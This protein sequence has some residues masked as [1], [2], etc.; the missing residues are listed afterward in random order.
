MNHYLL[1]YQ[2][3]IV[4][5]GIVTTV[6]FFVCRKKKP[7]LIPFALF[8]LCFTTV[9]LSSFLVSYA[10]FNV[11]EGSTIF[12]FLTAGLSAIIENAML[13][14][15]VRTYHVLFNFNRQKIE[16]LIGISMA[17]ASFMLVTPV[18]IEFIPKISAYKL[19][20]GYY[21]FAFI[22]FVVFTYIISISILRVWKIVDKADRHF[23]ILLFIFT[24]IGYIQSNLSTY[25]EL[26]ETVRVLTAE[27]QGFNPSTV[28]YLLFSLF[29]INLL[30][31]T[32][33][34][35]AKADTVPTA[36][37]LLSYGFSE[38]EK[39]LV[40]LILSGIS[41]QQIA[42]EL[43]ISLATVKTHLNKIFKKSDVKSRF[44]LA[45]KLKS[46]EST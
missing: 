25:F 19:R 10:L 1:A 16:W 17:L 6:L 39:E 32:I 18:G 27:S 33:V 28:M 26:G 4:M 12:I 36:E 8:Y 41:N 34:Q 13:F 29:L 30:F 40:P 31:R 46:S 42:D 37:K 14:F 23:G 24:F 5:V 45:Q 35:N 22:Y 3:M 15:I 21:I 7:Y 2:A 11:R 38:R 9:M 44:E 43:H 20:E